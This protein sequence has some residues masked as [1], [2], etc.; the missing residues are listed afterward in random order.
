MDFALLEKC[1]KTALCPGGVIIF[2]VEEDQI[3]TMDRLI[4]KIMPL[5]KSKNISALLFSTD[6]SVVMVPEARRVIPLVNR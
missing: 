3:D 4:Q 1:L 6:V 2:Q 5:L